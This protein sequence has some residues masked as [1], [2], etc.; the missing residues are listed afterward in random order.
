[1]T[2][3]VTDPVLPGQLQ[4]GQIDY[5]LVKTG[6]T[7][8]AAPFGVIRQIP[9]GSQPIEAKTG[10]AVFLGTTIQQIDAAISAAALKLGVANPQNVPDLGTSLGIVGAEI[11]GAAAGIYGASAAAA[12]ADAADAAAGAGGTAASST[13][14]ATSGGAASKLLSSTGGKVAG[15]GL[16]GILGLTGG[17]QQ[18][19]VRA[20]EALAGIALLLL[21]LQ[22]LTGTGSQGNPVKAARAVV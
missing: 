14:G 8:G 4:A 6:G 3:Y 13:A 18:L 12:A 5:W 20:L 17:W 11:T 16:A 7:A 2:S 19:L 15:A 9:H 22:A 21:G 1:M 10:N